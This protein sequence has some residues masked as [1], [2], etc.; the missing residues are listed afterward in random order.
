MRAAASY[1][2]PGNHYP[3]RQFSSIAHFLTPTALQEAFGSLRLSAF[4]RDNRSAVLAIAVL[5]IATKFNK[6][7]EHLR[8]VTLEVGI[9]L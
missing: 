6:R 9:P 3:A 4:A 1:R 2:P 8:P 7:A 5:G